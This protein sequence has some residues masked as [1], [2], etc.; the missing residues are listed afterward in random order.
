MLMGRK[1]Y[2][3]VY[4]LLIIA[5]LFALLKIVCVVSAPFITND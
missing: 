4:K 5:Y 2:K 1:A 3:I